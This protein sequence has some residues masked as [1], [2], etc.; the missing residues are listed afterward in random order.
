MA[1]SAPTAPTLPASRRRQ[2][3]RIT[4]PL[5]GLSSGVCRLHGET[6]G[7]DMCP[8]S[9]IFADST[10]GIAGALI[11]LAT[12]CWAVFT[13]AQDRQKRV[14]GIKHKALVAV[15]AGIVLCF[16]AST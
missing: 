4:T 2:R 16:G 11:A 1:T 9:A 10:S 13:W 14:L 8:T 15:V 6:P 5:A 12:L 7:T 3:A